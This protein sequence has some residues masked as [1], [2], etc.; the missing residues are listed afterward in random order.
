[1]N[2]SI[3]RI[4]L[5]FL[6]GLV[7]AAITTEL[8]YF[9]LKKENRIPGIIE[10]IIPAGTADLIRAGE[11]PPEIPTDMRFVVGDTLKVINQD[12]ENHQL[13]P[14]WIPAE[15][16]ASLKLE[17]EENLVFECSFQAGSY[18]GITVQ[19]PVTWRTRLSGYFFAGFPLGM[20]FAV[21]S[22]LVGTKKKKENE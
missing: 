16:S 2:F 20:M 7:L 11:A 10:L 9:F 21:Y 6:L 17:T 8:A 12:D 13:G 19:E 5:A 22:G 4:A 3:K 15:S 1:M 14:L 18:L